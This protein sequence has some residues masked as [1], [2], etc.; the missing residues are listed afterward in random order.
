MPSRLNSLFSRRQYRPDAMRDGRTSAHRGIATGEAAEVLLPLTSAEFLK[1]QELVTSL[2]QSSL[3]TRFAYVGLVEP[4]KRDVLAFASGTGSKPAR[5]ARVLTLGMRSGAEHD[6]RIDVDAGTV[7]AVTEIPGDKGRVPILDEE[8]QRVDRILAESAEWAAALTRRDVHVRDTVAVPLSPGYYPELGEYEGRILR[9]YAFWR[10]DTND[11]AWAHPI[12]GLCAFVDPI[13]GTVVKI[14]DDK[15]L[16]VPR[17][18]ENFHESEFRGPDMTS[19]KPI[20]ITQ[21]EGASFSV[22]GNHLTWA[23]WQLDFGFDAREGLVLRNLQYYDRRKGVDRDVIYRASIAEMVVPY[24]DPAMTRFWHNYFDAGEYLF[25]R[26]ANSLKLGCDCLGEIH[27]EDIV[28]ADERG[29]PTT[30][31]NGICIHEEDFGTLW[32]HTDLFTGGTDVRRQRRLVVSFFTTIGNYDYGFYWYLYLDGTIE[33]EAKLTGILFPS[34]LGGESHRYANEVAPG[35]GAPFHQHLFCARLDMAIDGP[36]NSAVE[37]EACRLP[38]GP[39]NPHGNAFSYAETPIESEAQGGRQHNAELGRVWHIASATERNFVD[40]PTAFVLHAQQVP[41]LLA[42]PSA[43]ISTRAAFTTRPVWFTAYSPSEMY[44][45]GDFVNQNPGVGGLA[46]WI[47][48]DRPLQGADIVLWHTFGMTHFP[49]PEDW[50]VMP[51]DYARFRLS[52][53][54]FFDGNPVLDVPA[55]PSG[56]CATGDAGPS[57]H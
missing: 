4:D 28:I 2:P 42:D 9:T 36:A 49:R 23:N 17:K 26:Y 50:P 20:E 1:V 27:Y 40:V 51:V 22:T 24:A 55:F 10:T 15:V 53:Y 41:M 45:S 25:A 57:C 8:F 32:K 13:A 31:A 30:I 12:D 47:K 6:I 19:L 33:C 21:P 3:D 44:P 34:A 5:Q 7:V 37:V 29:N 52:P 35:V 16:P 43:G 48:A 14:I 56:G 18:S 54:G 38:L 46:D 39:E 11:N